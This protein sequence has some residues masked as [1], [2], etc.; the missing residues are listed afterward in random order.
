MSLRVAVGSTNGVKINAVTSVFTRAF[1]DVQLHVRSIGVESGV[2]SQPTT[3]R[4]TQCGAVQRARSAAAQATYCFEGNANFSVG[5]EGGIR[6]VQVKSRDGSVQ[7]TMEC[8]AWIAVRCH[9][10]RWGL[11]RTASVELPPVVS[12]LLREGKELGDAIDETFNL[13][14]SKRADGAVGALTRGLMNRT[15]YYEHALVLALVAFLNAHLYDC[16]ASVD[17]YDCGASVVPLG[18]KSNRRDI[19]WFSRI[20]NSFSACLHFFTTKTINRKGPSSNCIRAKR[21]C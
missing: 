13:R 19:K 10:D 18:Q 16:T 9:D 14:D 15:E 17:L 3:E 12:K 20:L 4:E 7:S 5:I 8:F 11:S 2:P 1:P 21:A 6:E